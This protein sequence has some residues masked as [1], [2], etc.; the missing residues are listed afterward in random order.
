MC[1]KCVRHL[2]YCV[3]LCAERILDLNVAKMELFYDGEIFIDENQLNLDLTLC[4]GQSF[5]W[6]RDIQ[7][8]KQWKGVAY[9]VFWI[10]TQSSSSVKFKAYPL[11]T[12]VPLK[13]CNQKSYFENMLREY[14]RIDFDLLLHI[15]Q[16]KAAHQ[17]FTKM[18][19]KLTAVRV[20]KQEP[21]ENVVSFICSQ[22][23]HIGRISS[24]VRWICT[25]YGTKIGHFDGADEYTFPTL[26][27]LLLHQNELESTLKEAKF[28]YRAK[29]IS[30]AVKK[31][32]ENGGNNYL[33]GLKSIPYY[34]ARSELS[35]ISGIGLKCA[36]CICL[37]SLNH[38]EA[39]PIDVHMFKTAKTSYMPHL[40][41]S[42]T[43][44]TKIYNDI[45][46]HY[47]SI[48]G[49][50]AGWAQ[51]VLFCSSL[52]QS[53]VKVGNKLTKSKVIKANR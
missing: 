8:E 13:I 45:A 52:Q 25:K 41:T 11:Q 2:G 33:N 42:K 29:Y 23:N 15:E 10:L 12:S 51:A 44:T 37:M 22:N 39:V 14:L 36:D 7:Q 27:Q 53:K 38:L 26:S 9:E 16:W 35:K 28:G 5:R 18:D 34:E 3:K 24:M 21:F 50:F 6:R 32:H 46:N 40:S 49:P 4:G 31:I 30:Q 47:R 17:H 20:L 1:I 48:Y 43:M 19:S